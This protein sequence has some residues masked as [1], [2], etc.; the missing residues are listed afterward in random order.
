MSEQIEVEYL[1]TV[2]V[3]TSE[4]NIR[5]LEGAF[6]RL[7]GQLKRLTGNEDLNSFFVLEQRSLMAARSIQTAI[8]TTSA[9]IAGAGP[10]GWL[11]AGVSIVS[12]AFATTD[13][14]TSSQMG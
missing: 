10:V 7:G 11:V 14:L 2:N 1:L 8:T 9:A 5:K 12:A 6:I 4:I 3:E 13:L